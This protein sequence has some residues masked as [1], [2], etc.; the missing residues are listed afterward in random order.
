[1]LILKA[2][3]RNTRTGS[4]SFANSFARAKK[5]SS[6]GFACLLW[7]IG[8]TNDEKLSSS[9]SQPDLAVLSRFRETRYNS[10]QV[11]PTHLQPHFFATRLTLEFI[12]NL[13]FFKVFEI[14]WLYFAFCD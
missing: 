10:F 3:H 12:E 8:N 11:L 5:S 4:T 14:L 13:I 7:F 9:I 1:S 6:R 2:L